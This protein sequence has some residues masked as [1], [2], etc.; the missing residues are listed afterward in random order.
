M[1]KLG[2]VAFGGP[3]VHVA[4]L[5]DET[6]HRRH[7][8]DD[9]EFLDLF[10]AVSILPGP[11][12]TQLAIVLSRRRAGWLG[13]ALGRACFTTISP[14]LDAS[15]PPCTRQVAPHTADP[16]HL[17]DGEDHHVRVAIA[18]GVRSRDINVTTR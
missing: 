15:R 4:M 5:R 16:G 11:S 17:A 1:V 8:L 13:L 2:A 14:T 7:W 18:R 10:G 3:T 6:V 12:A 9:Q